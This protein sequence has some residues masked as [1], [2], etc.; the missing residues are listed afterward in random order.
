V[1]PRE[2][3]VEEIKEKIDSLNAKKELRKL[4]S[5]GTV[6]AADVGGLF[7]SVDD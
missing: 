2:I 5:K 7:K 6:S 4:I 1:I 3:N